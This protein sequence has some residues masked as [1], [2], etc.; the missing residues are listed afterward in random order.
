MEYGEFHKALAGKR[1]AEKKYDA[2]QEEILLLRQQL[3]EGRNN[4]ESLTRECLSLSGKIAT[5]RSEALHYA[6]LIKE[7]EQKFPEGYSVSDDFSTL[8]EH[9]EEQRKQLEEKRK[10]W[11]DNIRRRPDCCNPEKKKRRR[12][13]TRDSSAGK[14]RN[15]MKRC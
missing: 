10:R 4:R 3:E 14:I 15:R 7:E 8:L 13:K 2:L 6:A 1:E 12:P 5:A 11:T 9:T